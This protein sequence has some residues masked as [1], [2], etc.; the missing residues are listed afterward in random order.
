MITEHWENVEDWDYSNVGKKKNRRSRKVSDY[1]I[2]RA[3]RF[4][5]K[6]VFEQFPQVTEHV[7]TLHFNF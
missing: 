2:I 1:R 4:C 6:S 3:A 7:K 5:C